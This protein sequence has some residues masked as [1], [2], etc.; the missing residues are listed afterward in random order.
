MI[1]QNWMRQ[2]EKRHYT[3]CKIEKGIQR[4]GQISQTKKDFSS[5]IQMLLQIME[6]MY[7]VAPAPN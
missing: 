7:I 5:W 2:M 4:R 3:D 1:Y 6:L